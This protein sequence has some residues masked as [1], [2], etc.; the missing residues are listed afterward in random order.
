MAHNNIYSYVM[1][2]I[3]LSLVLILFLTGV[4]VPC[5]G[6]MSDIE[7]LNKIENSIFGF[8][9][10][11]EDAAT[12]VKRLEESV[13]GSSS[14]GTLNQRI[15]KLSKDLGAEFYG[16]EIEPCEDTL[17]REEEQREI[18]SS[19]DPNIDYP[20][21][22][23][24]EKSVF[25]QEYKNLKVKDRLAQLENKVFT[26]SY[27]NDDLSTRVDRLREQVRPQ[28]LEQIAHGADT[29]HTSG[30]YPDPID[31]DGLSIGGNYSDYAS[32]SLFDFSGRKVKLSTVE[33][34][35]YHQNFKNDTTSNRLSRIEQ[36]MFGQS[37]ADQDEGVRISRISS[38]FNAQKSANK[39]DSNKFTQNMATAM[40]I[41]TMIL[42][43]LACIL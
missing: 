37:F 43:I 40:Q 18:L 13:Y 21:I 34:A 33:N 23:E 3:L 41:G 20:V 5:A 32:D 25:N 22:N 6:A 15:G 35:L 7:T 17:A 16:Q 36:S 24:L 38:A 42:M 2:K 31:Y 14:T 8:E 30:Y 27:P 19:Q 26:T 39:Y 10:T 11:N 1:N 9:Y 4:F 29:F 12:R 28:G